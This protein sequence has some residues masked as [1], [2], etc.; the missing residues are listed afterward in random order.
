MA[1]IFYGDG[2]VNRTMTQLIYGDAGVN[3]IIQEAW[4]QDGGTLRKVWPPAVVSLTN[5]TIA[6]VGTSPGTSTA[7][8]QLLNTGEALGIVTP[9]GSGAGTYLPQWGQG[10]PGAGYD[11]RFT[12]TSGALSGGTAGVWLN[13]GT[14]RSWTRGRAALGISTVIGT[15]EIRDAGTLA[16]LAT[17]TI[18]LSA[19]IA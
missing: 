2:G 9:S 16:V 3:R 18:E 14:S 15:M 1:G 19:E 17:A 5:K 11:A 10:L 12:V 7:E 6:A 8:F 4:Y 13:L